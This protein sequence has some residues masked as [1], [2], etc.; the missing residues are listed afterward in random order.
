MP[1][2]ERTVMGLPFGNDRWAIMGEI[3][4]SIT[5]SLVLD[6]WDVARNYHLI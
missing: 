4:S 1:T 2:L 3:C 5:Y 6:E